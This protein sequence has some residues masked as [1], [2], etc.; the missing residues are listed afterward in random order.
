MKQIVNKSPAILLSAI[1]L[2]GVNGAEALTV[3]PCVQSNITISVATSTLD[4]A[5]ITPCT[6]T[7]GSV[8]ISPTNGARSTTGCISG[9][10][11]TVSRGVYTIAGN[12]P[13]G[14]T[15]VVTVATAATISTGTLSMSVTNIQMKQGTG[16]TF[17][18]GGNLTR[19]VEIGGDVNVGAGQASGDYTGTFTLS[20]TCI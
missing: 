11:G 13:S 1:C 19:T 10:R 18:F 14:R 15:I 2:A 20:A 16:T 12:N 3:P 9:T 5:D 4:F 6:A 17:S 7:S 8:V